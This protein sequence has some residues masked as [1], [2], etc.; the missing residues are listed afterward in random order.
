LSA[1]LLFVAA[2]CSLMRPLKKKALACSSWLF[3]YDLIKS[4]AAALNMFTWPA[5]W[6]QR[7]VK[8]R[9]KN[10]EK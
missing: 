3:F 9:A 7:K 10:K 6:G 8:S 4:T 5:N 1:D 2:F